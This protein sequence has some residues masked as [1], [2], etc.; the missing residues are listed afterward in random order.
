MSYRKVLSLGWPL[1][2]PLESSGPAPPW[3]PP[4]LLAALAQDYTLWDKVL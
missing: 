2:P 3:Q 1:V 4:A